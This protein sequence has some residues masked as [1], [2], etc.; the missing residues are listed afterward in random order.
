MCLDSS[1]HYSGNTC[2]IHGLTVHTSFTL[3]HPYPRL[4]PSVA[5]KY[6]NHIVL[7]TCNFIHVLNIDLEQPKNLDC[8]L[9]KS[10]N[11]NVPLAHKYTL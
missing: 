9:D 7:N 4:E 5:L 3:S 10:E 11:I 1:K 8:D 2:L 6:D